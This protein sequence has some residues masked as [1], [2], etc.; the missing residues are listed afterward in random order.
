M[1]GTFSGIAENGEAIIES[2]G[3]RLLLSSEEIT[4]LREK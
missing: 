1:T 3:N 4:L 2:N